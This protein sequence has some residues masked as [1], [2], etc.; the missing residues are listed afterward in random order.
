MI[1]NIL[2]FLFGMLGG[3]II[4]MFEIALLLVQ[5]GYRSVRDIPNSEEL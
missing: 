2:I 1:N 3:Y 5:K 4:A